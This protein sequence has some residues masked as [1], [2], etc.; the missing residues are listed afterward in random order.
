MASSSTT[1]ACLIADPSTRQGAA[2]PGRSA[3]PGGPEGVTG[4]DGTPVPTFIPKPTRCNE[5]APESRGVGPAREAKANCAYHPT[6]SP[7][8]L[9]E[10]VANPPANLAGRI[11]SSW[12]RILISASAATLILSAR[13]V[14]LGR[15]PIPRSAARSTIAIMHEL[16][17][18]LVNLGAGLLE[19]LLSLA[20]DA[21]V[22][23]AAATDKLG[24]PPLALCRKWAL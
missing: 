21:D 15:L 24:A 16:C 6:S 10:S 14:H 7:S 11:S 17:G 1:G 22:L 2:L 3:R 5:S 19:Q 12:A 13:F 20:R 4:Q 23:P 9:L 18:Q 8:G